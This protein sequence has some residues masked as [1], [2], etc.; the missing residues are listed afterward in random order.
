MNAKDDPRRK[1]AGTN[2]IKAP[3]L[4]AATLTTPPPLG[5]PAGPVQPMGGEHRLDTAE[6]KLDALAAEI[7]ELSRRVTAVGARVL[8]LASA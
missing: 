1:R 7:A 2:P 3:M 4:P 8:L 5:T 6:L